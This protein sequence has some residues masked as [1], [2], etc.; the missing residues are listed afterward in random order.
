M[1][2]ICFGRSFIFSKRLL[3]SHDLCGIFLRNKRKP[4]F[5]FLLPPPKTLTITLHLAL[6]GTLSPQHTHSLRP[7]ALSPFLSPP[8]MTLSLTRC[9][10]SLLPSDDS[11]SLSPSLSPSLF[12]AFSL[13]VV[14]NDGPPSRYRRH[15]PSFLPLG[16]INVGL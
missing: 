8:Y 11:L 15:Y 2:Y 10:P 9:S 7:H 16:Q 6:P 4:F 3:S 5:L 13:L 14:V 1:R 12:I